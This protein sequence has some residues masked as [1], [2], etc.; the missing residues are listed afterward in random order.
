MGVSDT[1][2]GSHAYVTSTF[3]CDQVYVSCNNHR[4]EAFQ[5]VVEQ[6]RIVDFFSAFGHQIISLF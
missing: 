2:N 6:M 1:T 3:H 5:E 4:P